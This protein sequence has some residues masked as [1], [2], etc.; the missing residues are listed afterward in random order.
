MVKD[1]IQNLETPIK[2]LLPSGSISLL[3]EQFDMPRQNVASILRGEWVNEKVLEA[4]L[5]LID[6]NIEKSTSTKKI[7]KDALGNSL[8]S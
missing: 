3:A 5:R 7:I 1:I 8:P 6:T 4:A 2:D